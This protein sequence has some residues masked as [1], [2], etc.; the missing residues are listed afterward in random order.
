MSGSSSGFLTKSIIL[1]GLVLLCMGTSMYFGKQL[2]RNIMQL[3]RTNIERNFPEYNSSEASDESDFVV[4][5]ASGRASFGYNPD[6]F[7]AN[8]FPREWADPGEEEFE[9][10]SE[11]PSVDIAILDDTEAGESATSD[12]SAADS[13]ATEESGEAAEQS[14]GDSHIFGLGG[15]S[16]FRIQVGTYGERE[17]AENVW[18]S[19]TT[20]GYDASVSTYTDEDKVRYRVTVGTYHGRE[21]ADAIAEQL[22]SMNF[23]AWVYRVE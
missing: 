9:D 1:L 15:D 16:V 5:V 6:E 7:G 22:R 14:R 11:D 19:L 4:D 3:T 8:Q 21:E 2:G 18:N 10:V 17:N 20:A 23:D 12:E 13:G